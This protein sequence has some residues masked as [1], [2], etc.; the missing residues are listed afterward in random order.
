MDHPT[1]RLE[2]LL[3]EDYSPQF[4]TAKA[5]TDA[6]KATGAMFVDA[7]YRERGTAGLVALNKVARGEDATLEA[8]RQEL[9]RYASELE[10]VVADG[11]GSI[12]ALRRDQRRLF[13]T[14]AT[15]NGN[16]SGM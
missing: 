10:P 14:G 7:V 6:L 4:G 1:V 2:D 16:E 9:P 3:R 11:S 13:P 15:P 12:A 5:Q 8:M